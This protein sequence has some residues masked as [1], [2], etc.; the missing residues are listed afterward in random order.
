MTISS[1]TPPDSR[2]EHIHR[3]WLKL[4]EISARSDEKFEATPEEQAA[5]DFLALRTGL[6][7]A[8]VGHLTDAARRFAQVQAELRTIG[9]PSVEFDRLG[10][11]WQELTSGEKAAAR[12]WRAKIKPVET[13][14]RKLARQ[15][16]RAG[17]LQQE[18]ETLQT[19]AANLQVEF[20]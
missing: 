3:L 15:I 5:I 11:K 17:A 9:E 2:K 4:V 8:D 12:A 6:R 16:L 1:T 10:Q 19:Q 18:S 7:P 14:R 13:R 20:Y